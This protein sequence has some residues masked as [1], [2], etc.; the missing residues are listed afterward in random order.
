MP[1][2]L[3]EDILDDN[4][5]KVFNVKISTKTYDP[6][7]AAGEMVWHSA[8]SFIDTVPIFWTTPNY[9]K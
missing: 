6:F 3:N 2:I 9:P 4:D 5:D 8:P 1:S 7:F